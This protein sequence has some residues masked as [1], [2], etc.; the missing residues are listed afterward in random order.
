MAD[1]N[2]SNGDK[3]LAMVLLEGNTQA[4]NE[5]LGPLFSGYAASNLVPLLRSQ[6]ERVVRAGAWLIS[7]LGSK[8]KPL[9]D[10]FRELLGHRS[11]EV[12]FF[13]LDA[14]LCCCDD[15]DGDIIAAAISLAQDQDAAVRWKLI[16]FLAK[17]KPNQLEAGKLALSDTHL[18]SL[19]TWLQDLTEKDVAS[20]S[21]KKAI[22]AAVRE[23]LNSSFTPDRL[24]G[25]A[26]VAKLYKTSPE[27]IEICRN[28]TDPD[29]AGFI[30]DFRI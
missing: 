14:V 1:N 25:A 19:I 24:F 29:V 17:L 3:L 4:A 5:L 22:A 16:Y 9:I 2:R 26:G 23:K 10:T 20:A 12:R 6:D 11:R 30:R 15:H 28:S 8:A 21:S 13:V 18:A 7:E 27:L